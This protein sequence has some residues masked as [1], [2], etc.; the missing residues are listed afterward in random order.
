[1]FHT[2]VELQQKPPDHTQSGT[3][4]HHFFLKLKLGQKLTIHNRLTEMMHGNERL[5]WLSRTWQMQFR[6]SFWKTRV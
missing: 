2:Q 1:M 4:C 3:P 5:L 6:R